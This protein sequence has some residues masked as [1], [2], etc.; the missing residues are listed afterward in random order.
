MHRL[1]QEGSRGDRV[2]VERDWQRRLFMDPRIVAYCRENGVVP[3][4]Y[5]EAERV[6]EP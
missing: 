4:R 2:A 5:D 1:G 3:I 6:T